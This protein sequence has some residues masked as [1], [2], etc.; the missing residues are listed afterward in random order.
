VISVQ[1]LA[2]C[3]AFYP[4]V[5]PFL[6]DWFRSFKQ[7][8]DG[9]VQLWIALDAM[10]ISEALDILGSDPGAN[11]VQA[12]SGDTP[13]LVRQR[14]L[15]QVVATCD[16]VV[17]V[18]SDD[19]LHPN[20]V[21]AAR[22]SLQHSDLTGCA[23]RLVNA[24]GGDMGGAGLNLPPGTRPEAILPR[25]NI[26]GLSNT[27]WRSSALQHCLPIPA[28]V[29][30]VDWFLATRAWLCGLRLSFDTTVY[31]DYRQ[32]GE[33]MVRV[34][35]PFSKEQLAR[36]TA[37]ALRHFHLIRETPIHGILAARQAQLEEVVVDI[38][39]FCAHVL[40]DEEQLSAYVDALNAL[41]PEPLW[42]SS[43][44]HPALKYLW[45]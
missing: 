15:E 41:N 23:L 5:K 4:G 13:A 35:A 42:W 8:T 6:G 3:T 9:D 24:Q 30:I 28:A 44:A 37:R 17:L 33:N 36:D 45:S 10:E 11:W 40:R 18:D 16:A 7:Q 29:E 27:A 38:D 34:L 21:A 12:D 1:S 2:L 26:F 32:H 14:L 39:R 25:N 19:I 22:S 31:M 43:V 20:R